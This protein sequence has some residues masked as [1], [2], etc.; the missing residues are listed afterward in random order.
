MVIVLFTLIY[1][2]L[3]IVYIYLFARKVKHGPE[4]AGGEVTV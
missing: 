1:T 4:P 3:G 2:L